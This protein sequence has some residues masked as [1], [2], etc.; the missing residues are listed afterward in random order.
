MAIAS[1]QHADV[2]ALEADT[3]A[4][5]WMREITGQNL[6]AEEIIIEGLVAA[7]FNITWINPWSG[8]KV[9]SYSQ[10]IKEDK[11][12]I[13]SPENYPK[14]D[15]SFIIKLKKKKNAYN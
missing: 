13:K 12:K 7:D 15:I 6:N 11:L 10:G 9:L 4:I 8:D 14:A 1:A 2:F 3:I 5:G